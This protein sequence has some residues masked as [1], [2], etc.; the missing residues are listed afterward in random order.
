[1]WRPARGTLPRRR[2]QIAESHT[3]KE[4]DVKH[5]AIVVGTVLFAVGAI[6]MAVWLFVKQRQVG[7]ST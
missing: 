7:A 1:M 6:A 3:H 5:W 2:H 4:A